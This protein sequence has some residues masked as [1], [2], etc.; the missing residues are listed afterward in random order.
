[1]SR[2]LQLQPPLLLPPLLV[3][4]LLVPPPLLP[5]LLPPQLLLVP[6]RRNRE[7]QYLG[8]ECDLFLEQC[9]LH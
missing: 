6:P 3:P 4:P 1:M 8:H 2:L 9:A 5:L 7:P